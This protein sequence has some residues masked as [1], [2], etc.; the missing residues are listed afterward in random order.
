MICC[1]SLLQ[2]IPQKKVCDRITDCEDGTDEI[3]C[4]CKDYLLTRHPTAI[5]DGVTDCADLSDEANC[6]E[7]IPKNK[8]FKLL[9]FR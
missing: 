6:T 9:C 7:T 3:G 4:T 1:Y 8:I 2:H 5:C